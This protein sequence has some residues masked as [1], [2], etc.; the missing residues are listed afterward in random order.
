MI[1]N[2]SR[3]DWR[4]WAGVVASCVVA[5]VVA[6]CWCPLQHL[7]HH[8]CFLLIINRK[9]KVLD[10]CLKQKRRGENFTCHFLAIM[11][12]WQL[13]HYFSSVGWMVL[14]HFHQPTNQ[15]MS[16]RSSCT[17]ENSRYTLLSLPLLYRR[18]Q[19]HT[20]TLFSYKRQNQCQCRPCKRRSSSHSFLTSSLNEFCKKN[21]MKN[22]SQK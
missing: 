14:W 13:L 8:K 6:T 4:R 2:H 9:N 10:L 19:A 7:L 16:S 15:P 3:W 1:L 17:V 21:A 11:I 12:V 5:V 22:V 18:T 20:Y